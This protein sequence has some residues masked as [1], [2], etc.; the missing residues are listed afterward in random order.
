MTILAYIA[1]VFTGAGIGVF[2]MAMVVAA[3]RKAPEPD[4]YGGTDD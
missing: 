3:A 2:V 4:N 1:G